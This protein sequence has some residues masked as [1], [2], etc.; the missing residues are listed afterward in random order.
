MVT[1]WRG[2]PRHGRPIGALAG[3][4]VGGVCAALSSMLSIT[5]GVI[6]PGWTIGPAI[7]IAAGFGGWLLAPLAWR[8][9]TVGEWLGAIALL[10]FVAAVIG[11]LVVVTL[12]G[13]GGALSGSL[14][15]TDPPG[16]LGLSLGMAGLF[17]LGLLV[18]GPFAALATIPAATVWAIVM[19]S[20]RGRFA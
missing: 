2:T 14:S 9:R 1:V 4:F 11:D 3:L 18:V 19:R 6:P 20:L 17:V 8:A 10:A 16:P 5:D 15:P 7:L 13:S 12:I